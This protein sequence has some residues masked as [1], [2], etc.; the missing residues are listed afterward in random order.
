MKNSLVN[1]YR[2]TNNDLKH[3]NFN[4]LL[5]GTTLTTILIIN[6]DLFA[7]NVGDSKAV[8]F[9]IRKNLEGPK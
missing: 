2:K 8:M 3:Q 4:S 7:S 5:S 1:S 9:K 6:N